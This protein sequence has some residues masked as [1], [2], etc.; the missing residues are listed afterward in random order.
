MEGSMTKTQF[1]KQYKLPHIPIRYNINKFIPKGQKEAP[2]YIYDG[3]SKGWK[4]WDYQKCCDY[5]EQKLYNDGGYYNAWSVNISKSNFVV[6]DIDN[7]DE[8]DLKELDKSFD[9]HNWVSL[10][11]SKKLPHLWRLTNNKEDPRVSQKPYQHPDDKIDLIYDHINESME[12][13]IKYTTEQMPLFDCMVEF[14]DE[15]KAKVFNKVKETKTIPPSQLQTQP[16]TSTDE[17]LYELA[18]ILSP[19]YYAEGQYENWRKIMWACASVDN[20]QLAKYISSKQENWDESKAV[21]MIE[22]LFLNW[23]GKITMGTFYHACKLSNSEEYEKIISKYHQKKTDELSSIDDT[24]LAKFY[25]KLMSDN[26][27]KSQDEIYIYQECFW[28]KCEK[29][30]L[31]KSIVE[32]LEN[33][34]KHIKK[35]TEQSLKVFTD[36]NE[37]DKAKQQEELL[38]FIKKILS[39]IYSQRHQVDI[40]KQVDMFVNHDDQINWDTRQPYYFSFK[41]T[42]FDLKT[43]TIVQPKKTDYI[44]ATTGYNWVEPKEDDVKELEEVLHKILPVDDLY[45]GVLSVFRTAL[46]GIKEQYLHTFKGTGG[47]GKSL[48]CSLIHELMGKD[49]AKEGDESI[50]VYPLKDGSPN[51]SASRL[52]KKRMATWEEPPTGSHI[53]SNNILKLTG[54]NYISARGLYSNRDETDVKALTSILCLNHLPNIKGGVDL[55]IER[56]FKIWDFPSHFTSEEHLIDEAI[57]KYRANSEYDSYEW[58]SKMKFALFKILL[59]TTTLKSVI[60][61]RI[62]DYSKRVL[63]K[64]NTFIGW[65]LENYKSVEIP[66]NNKIS[67]VLK[68]KDVYNRLKESEFYNLSSKQDKRERLAEKNITVLIS[69]NSILKGSYFDRKN[70]DGKYYRNILLGWEEIPIEKDEDSNAEIEYG[71]EC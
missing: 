7:T 36:K 52:H 37:I 12:G 16:R 3:E 14:N 43:N 10:S 18:D 15:T 23:D 27:I 21:G 64:S 38:G 49:Y 46:F 44:Y 42:T 29:L 66:Q 59:K 69:D 65:F 2:K 11:N 68:M 70:I 58:K 19:V 8:E 53:Q 26:I 55:A 13:D 33:H 31:Q 61:K 5:T 4:S 57:H 63:A 50:I 60:S 25:L 28:K 62:N 1:F 22:L 54:N 45:E 56:R 47:N 48:I 32:T 71:E 34:Y 40:L 20:F 67:V 39:K 24:E 41:N 17:E 9:L 35:Q 6:I 51:V 30:D